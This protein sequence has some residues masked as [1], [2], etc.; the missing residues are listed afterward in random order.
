[1]RISSEGT[2]TVIWL[3]GVINEHADLEASR[4]P[5]G[6]V[7]VLD[8]GAVT[9]INSLGVRNWLVFIEELCARVPRVVIRQLA[10]V[11]V[12]QLAAIRNFLGTAELESYMTPWVC[13]S[14]ERVVEFVQRRSERMHPTR[15]CPKCGTAMTLDALPDCYAG[16]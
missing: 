5:V 3:S 1:M 13:P 7:V 6:R 2:E 10:T 8:A 12:L 4:V 14:C 11:L 9:N 16:L 15:P